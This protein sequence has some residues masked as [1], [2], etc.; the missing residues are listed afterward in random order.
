MKK[1]GFGVLNR[2]T[3]K[4]EIITDKRTAILTGIKR[5]LDVIADFSNVKVIH[6]PQMQT[7]GTDSQKEAH[8]IQ[9]T[10]SLLKTLDNDN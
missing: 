1:H 9:L 7:T 3:G 5:R 6:L 2:T 4:T 8:A 10:D